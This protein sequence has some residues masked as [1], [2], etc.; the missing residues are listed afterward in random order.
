MEAEKKSLLAELT[1]LEI[2]R[3]I[4][5]TRETATV[6]IIDEQIDALGEK[7]SRI[8]YGLSALNIQATIPGQWIAPDIE[9][10]RG[11]FLKRGQP[12]GLVADLDNVLIRAT[13]GQ[14]H[15]A[16][17]NDHDLRQVEIRFKGRP[18]VTLAGEIEQ[19]YPAGQEELPSEALG[20]AVGGSMPT[21]V[22]DPR[23]MTT[24]ENF[25]EVRI[26]PVIDT[27]VNDPNNPLRLLPGQRIVARIQMPD[28]PLALQWWKSLRRLFQRRFHI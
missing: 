22:E 12:L 16:M 5:E 26:K 9:K 17:L 2:K 3:R 18:D 21:S 15:A 6:Q 25:F 20:Y 19:I 13:A 10:T 11:M 27:T 23:G 28:K 4:A 8:D 14:E 24:A 1:A 7:I